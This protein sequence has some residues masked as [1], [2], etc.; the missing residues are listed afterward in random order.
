MSLVA[1]ESLNCSACSV[2]ALAIV[3]LK[4][5]S[6]ITIGCCCLLGVSGLGLSTY[7]LIK[8]L[9]LKR[10]LISLQTKLANL[11]SQLNVKETKS[12]LISQHQSR[13]KEKKSKNIQFKPNISV[14]YRDE[15]SSSSVEGSY[16]TPDELTS[17]V[18]TIQ[19]RAF[20]TD[21]NKN[22]INNFDLNLNDNRSLELLQMQ[23]LENKR[24]VF[25]NNQ[26]KY[27]QVSKVL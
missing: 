26:C 18:R 1:L 3:S 2:N 7:L 11:T 15:S 12:V 14:E 19:S 10:S 25:Q 16:E 4:K 27:N 20:V 9:K 22:F 13:S 17:P 5:W 24:L 23:T 6:A 8:Y 21:K